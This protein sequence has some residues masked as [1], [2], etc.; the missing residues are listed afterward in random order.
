MLLGAVSAID[1]GAREVRLGELRVP[2]DY[3]VLATGASHS[4]FGRD[5]WAPYAPG[6]KRVEDATEVR[7]RVL[8]AFER[9]ESAGD[10]AEQR[11]LLTFLVVGGG[12]TGVELAGA[13][14]ELARFGMEKDFRSFDP[15]QARVVLVQAAPRLLPAFDAQ[16]SEKARRAL[17]AMGVEVLTDSRVEKIDEAGV[18]VSG[19]R[20]EARTVL[21]AAGVVASPAARW[22]NAPADSA[23]R[24]LVAP[25]LSV[26]GRPEIFA[27]GDTAA[28]KDAG[29]GWVPGLAPAAKQGRRARGRPD[30]CPARGRR[31][32]DAVPLSPPR[33][34]GDHRAQGRGGGFRAVAPE[35]RAGMVALGP[36]P[37][38]LPGRDAQ[39]HFGDVRLDV[40]VPDLPQ[41]LAPD[42]R[43]A[44]RSGK[45]ATASRQGG[46]NVRRRLAHRPSRQQHQKN[47]ARCQ[48]AT[49]TGEEL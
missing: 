35:R 18:T 45:R 32:D 22:L 41:R 48:P 12:P 9:A 15:A 49:T 30:P 17:Q 23:G 3:L 44:C 27:I 8:S 13:I 33:Q 16:L 4:Y 20:I 5:E 10:A 47:L 37:C 6:L 25:D 46:G 42:H 39:P 38:R 19:K 2:Y 7:A 31:R 1:T 34:P 36:D 40:V 24:V 14:A 28:V 29:G 11:R 26:P 43:A 21:W